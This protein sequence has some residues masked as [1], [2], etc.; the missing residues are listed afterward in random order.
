MNVKASGTIL[1]RMVSIRLSSDVSYRS[2]EM[3]LFV[4]R[5]TIEPP[6]VNSMRNWLTQ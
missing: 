6:G 5:G 1:M 3:I 4:C 2:S